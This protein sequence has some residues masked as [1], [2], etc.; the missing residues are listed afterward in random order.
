MIRLP[1]HQPL[2]HPGEVLQEEFL[3]PLGLSQTELAKRIGVSFRRVNELVNRKRGI[4]PDTALRF[5]K[6]FGTTPDLWMNMQATWDLWHVLHGREGKEI[7][8]ID[9]LETI[10]A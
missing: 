6:F 4:T 1:T 9:P 5:S 7:E 8:A 3:D 2:P 10:H